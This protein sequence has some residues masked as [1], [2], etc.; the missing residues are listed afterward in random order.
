MATIEITAGNARDVILGNRIVI[1]DFWADWCA[2]CRQFAPTFEDASE[3]HPAIVFG[4]VDTEAERALAADFGIT[5]I[6]TLIAF[7][8]GIGVYHE[9]GALPASAL[10]SLLDRVETLD[11]DEVRARLAEDTPSQTGSAPT[12]SDQ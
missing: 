2:P 9:A 10:E 11:M 7:R 5:G 6:P 12:G 8:D 4:K 3:Q 1:L